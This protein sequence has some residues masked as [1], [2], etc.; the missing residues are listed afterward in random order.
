MVVMEFVYTQGSL[1]MGGVA[2]HAGPHGEGPGMAKSQ[3]DVRGEQSPE[4]FWGYQEGMRKARQAD[5]L[6]EFRDGE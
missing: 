5:V 1:E 3:R 6:S 2:H 4:R